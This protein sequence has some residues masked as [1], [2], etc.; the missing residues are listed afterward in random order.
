MESK[1]INGKYEVLDTLLSDEYQS[2]FV[3]K[4]LDSDVEEN[5]ILNEFRDNEII[6][7]IKNSICYSGDSVS[8]SLIDSFEVDGVFYTLFPIPKGTPLEEYLSKHNLTLADKMHFTDQLLQ[9]FMGIDKSIPLIQYTLAD[10][11]NLTV[12]SRK[13]LIF[14][15]LFCFDKNKLQVSFDA[16]SKKIGQIICCIF[17]N[18]PEGNIEKDK[19]AIPPGMFP[20]VIKALEGSY[21][22]AKQMYQDFKNTLLYKTF[23]DNES[24]DEQIRKNIYKAKKRYV[25]YWPRFITSLLILAVLLSGGFWLAT[26][27]IPA[28]I[29][30]LGSRETVRKENTA[31]VAGFS[32]SINKVYAGDDVTF[33]DKSSDS[34][35]GDTIESRLWT[36]EKNGTVIL[37]SDEETLSF[38][39]DE[40]GNYTIS[41]IVQDSMGTSSEPFVH[42][43]KV[44]EKLEIPEIETGDTDS[45]PDLK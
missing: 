34:D 11:N 7:T 28:F 6:D 1:I 41:L 30:K 35:P 16:V 26:K 22:S 29:S 42:N 17:A 31:P 14:S 2:V 25:I 10:L 33:V 20:I 24:L 21:D 15:Y 37:N 40:P 9:N 3:C 36:I 38:V 32:I 27:A 39:F 18:S 8:E 12:I 19:D 23:I 43:L 44:L 13:F 45:P 5:F 4:K